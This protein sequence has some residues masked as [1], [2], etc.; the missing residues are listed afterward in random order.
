M[1][2]K[3]LFTFVILGMP[4]L[5]SAQGVG[6]EVQQTLDIKKVVF[7][8][9][10]RNPFL[11]KEEVIKIDQMRKAE[12]HRLEAEAAE[13]QRLA[14]EERMRRLR[15]EILREELRRHPSR[16]VMDKLNVE[17]ILG[18]QAIVNQEVVNIG[19]KIFGAKIVAITDNSVWFIYK[20]E[21]FERKL[22]LL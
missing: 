22:P 1:K 15:E 17:G 16:E 13:R 4:F 6:N 19:T 9:T 12:K 11:S 3:L 20:G 10:K 7:N 14:R 18:S 21:R 2:K 5:L 8:A